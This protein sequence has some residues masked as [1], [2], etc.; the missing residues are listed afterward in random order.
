MHNLVGPIILASVF[1][2]RTHDC[3]LTCNETW[4]MVTVINMKES[5]EI[6]WLLIYD[7]ENSFK[8]SS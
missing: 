6:C 5:L 7:M 4:K 8:E 1:L 2:D 3:K